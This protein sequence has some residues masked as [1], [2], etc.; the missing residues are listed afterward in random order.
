MILYSV[1]ASHR[2]H[3]SACKSPYTGI[4]SSSSP[5][6]PTASHRCVL[7]PRFSPHPPS[8]ALDAD[9]M[10]ARSS[11]G[12]HDLIPGSVQQMTYGSNVPLMSSALEADLI[13]AGRRRARRHHRKEIARIVVDQWKWFARGRLQLVSAVRH[14]RWVRVQAGA[15]Y[16]RL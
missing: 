11:T 3:S 12:I 9:K 8:R 2:K 5:G 6:T 1:H 14:Y 7:D 10:Q 16:C 4:P 13:E 15:R